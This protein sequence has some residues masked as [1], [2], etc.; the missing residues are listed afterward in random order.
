MAKIKGVIL[1]AG[2]GT[3][4]RPLTD[5]TPK[6]L[7]PFCGVPLFYLAMARLIQVGI[8][9]LATN[10]HYLGEKI[11]WA[12]QHNPFSASVFV[13]WERD[14]IL[15]SG[16][17]YGN[18]HAWRSNSPL[19][20]INGDVVSDFDLQ[21]LID[22]HQVTDSWVTLGLVKGQNPSGK[23]VWI[24]DD[25]MVQAISHTPPM[26]DVQLYPHIFSGCQVLSDDFLKEFVPNTPAD[27]ITSFDRGLA[28][29]RKIMGVYQECFWHDLGTPKSYFTAHQEIL[30]HPQQPLTTPYLDPFGYHLATTA[31]KL[32]IHFLPAGTV[33]GGYKVK[34]PTLLIGD[35]SVGK[36]CTLGPDLVAQGELSIPPDSQISNCIILGPLSYPNISTLDHVIVHNSLITRF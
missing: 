22:R 15:G 6:P 13:S 3:R 23:S 31:L 1:A 27:L 19:L 11:E 5:S 17:V 12:A 9:D 36:G 26:A 10:A 28:N 18:M 34:G 2:M 4:L 7:L 29:G 33:Q 25:G 8:K 20:A 32:P 35:V 30:N 14:Q 16:G 21:T 24:D